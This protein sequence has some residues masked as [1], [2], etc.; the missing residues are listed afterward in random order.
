MS[1]NRAV[2]VRYP[3]YGVPWFHSRYCAENEMQLRLRRSA[4]SLA[5]KE[6]VAECLSSLLGGWRYFQENTFSE[7]YNTIDF[8]VHLTEEGSPVDLSVDRRPS[9]EVTKVAIL[10]LPP[11]MFTVDTRSL[12]GYISANTE[13]LKLQNWKVIEVNPYNWNSL[14]MGDEK[15]K[16]EYLKQKLASL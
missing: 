11:N 8:E 10:V 16:K 4:E 13:E 5:M 12:A 9:G 15:A 6:E 1:L 7:Y 3:Q 2:V 14:Q